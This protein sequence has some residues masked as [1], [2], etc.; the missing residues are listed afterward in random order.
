MLDILGGM[1]WVIAIPVA[2]GL[3]WLLYAT[4]RRRPDDGGFAFVYVDKAGG[5]REL[6]PD[7]REHLQTEYRGDDGARPYIKLRYESRTPDGRLDGYLE[8]RRLPRRIAIG[9]AQT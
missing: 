4:R 9:P 7:E 3:L 2:V 5:A 8:R 6:T 1:F